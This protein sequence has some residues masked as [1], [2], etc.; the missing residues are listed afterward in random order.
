MRFLRIILWGVLI[1]FSS[2]MTAQE[3]L[4][5]TLSITPATPLNGKGFNLTLHYHLN[6]FDEFRGGFSLFD[7]QHADTLKFATHLFHLDYV[8]G[9]KFKRASLNKFGYYLGI[10]LFTGKEQLNKFGY[11]LG[12]GLFTGKE[13]S[14]PDDGLLRPRQTIFGL[15]PFIELEWTALPQLTIIG[16]SGHTFAFS[17]KASKNLELVLGTRLYF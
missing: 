8:K 9:F 1:F 6:S 2:K 17:D 15:R 7:Y 3:H 14:L 10:G 16:R 5:R 12:I 13:Q 4:A 11:Y